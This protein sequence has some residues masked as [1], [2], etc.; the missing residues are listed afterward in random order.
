MDIVMCSSMFDVNVVLNVRYDHDHIQVGCKNKAKDNS[1]PTVLPWR[2]QY[3]FYF[4]PSLSNRVVV[5]CSMAR[6]P[7]KKT[8][9][10]DGFRFPHP[11]SRREAQ[12][13]QGHN[14]QELITVTVTK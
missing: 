9:P 7:K 3:E 10:F 11:H 12:R 8:D 1:P 2:L 13:Q 4:F 6:N 14:R 5:V